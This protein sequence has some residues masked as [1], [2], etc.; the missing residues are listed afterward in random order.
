MRIIYRC[1]DSEYYIT[2]I[3]YRG[4]RSSE[5]IVLETTNRFDVSL[6]DKYSLDIVEFG[7]SSG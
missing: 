5:G 7:H 3:Q 1:E 4:H 2:P 6:A